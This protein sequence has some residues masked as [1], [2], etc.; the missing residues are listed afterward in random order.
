MPD[1]L[2]QK[3]LS[4]F[5]LARHPSYDRSKVKAGILHI[6]VGGFHRAHQAIYTEDVLA[7]GDLDGALLGLTYAAPTCE[8]DSNH[9]I[10]FT[11]P[12]QDI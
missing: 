2:S 10:F 8:T 9:R 4:A 12:A 7:S 11:Q 5:S 6:G 3:T 1:R